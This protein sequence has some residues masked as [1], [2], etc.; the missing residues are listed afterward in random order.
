MIWLKIPKYIKG[1]TIRLRQLSLFDWP[2]LNSALKDKDI[3]WSSGLSMPRFRSWFSF[4]WWLRRTYCYPYVIEVCSRR[5][6]F[7]GLYNL[8]RDRSV[9]MSLVIFCN[10]D[11]RK[12]YG[13]KAF[14]LLMYN[15][16]QSLFFKKVIVK[17]RVR[18]DNSV[19]L[20]FWMKLRFN[21]MDSNRGFIIM[22]LT[23]YGGC[24]GSLSLI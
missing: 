21:E 3:L 10:E 13:T 7:I 4:W 17:V 19:S 16:Q 9:E 8:R 15:I 2:F 20:S 23:I 12:G 5:I 11:R 14:H 6:G 22:A 18:E 1:D 24:D